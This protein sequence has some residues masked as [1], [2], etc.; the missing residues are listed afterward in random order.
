M[1]NINNLNNWEHMEI[2]SILFRLPFNT[3]LTGY[4]M[5]VDAIEL[6]LRCKNGRLNLGKDVYV[7][8]AKKYNINPA[9]VEKAIKGVIS[10]VS[11]SNVSCSSVIYP[12]LVV[13]NALIDGRPKHFISAMCELVRHNKLML[14]TIN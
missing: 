13:K 7:K 9:S 5:L 4:P 8:I 2:T 1:D 3:A 14:G 12:N 10:S 6:S 11:Q